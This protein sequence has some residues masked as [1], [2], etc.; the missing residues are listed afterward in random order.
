MKKASPLKSVKKSMAS[1]MTARLSSAR[2]EGG[3]GNPPLPTL[4]TEKKRAREREGGK[5]QSKPHHSLAALTQGSEN[6]MLGDFAKR[7]PIDS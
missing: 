5:R 7:W 6:Q 4:K 1:F 2:C 3:P